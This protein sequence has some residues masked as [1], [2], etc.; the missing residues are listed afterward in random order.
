MLQALNDW[1]NSVRSEARALTDYNILLA[2]LERQTGTILETH[3]LV[4]VEERFQAAG[5]HCLP[6][7]DRE[8]PRDLKPT[9]EPTRYPRSGG[10]GENAFDLTKPDIRPARMKE[11]ARTATKRTN[12]SRP[13][14][15]RGSAEVACRW[16]ESS[17][18]TIG[19]TVGLEDSATLKT[20]EFAEDRPKSW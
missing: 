14:V 10:P 9:G 17:R 1:G 4:F 7:H 18:P 12:C 5:P 16:A 11:P 20:T 19:G 15:C 13:Q 8:Y 2:T 3:G 6:R